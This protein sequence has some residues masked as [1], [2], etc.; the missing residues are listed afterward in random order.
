MS[1][2]LGRGKVNDG[3]WKEGKGREEGG[4][5]RKGHVVRYV[6]VQGNLVRLRFRLS[7]KRRMSCVGN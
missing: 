4:L 6:L 7:V 5:R 2:G 3:R 1:S